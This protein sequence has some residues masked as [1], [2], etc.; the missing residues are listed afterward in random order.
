MGLVG[1]VRALTRHVDFGLDFRRLFSTRLV[2]QCAD[3][4]FQVS[5]AAAVLFSPERETDPKKIAAGFAVLLLPFSIVGPFAGVFLDRWRRQRVL[6]RANLVRT[7]FVMVVA[8]LL[9]SGHGAGPSLYAAALAALSVNRL[10]LA[11]LSASL[12]HVVPRRELVSANS[13][14]TTSGTLVALL[15]GALG[16]GL[17]ALVG[18]GDG[19]SAV[20]ALVGGAG[21]LL[22]AAVAS[23]MGADLLGPVHPAAMP[24][25]TALTGVARGLVAGGR[26]VVGRP[27]AL[28]A[29]LAISAHRFAYGLGLV[30]TL[31][32]Y[33]NYFPD[34]GLLR[35]GL[36]GLAEMSVAAF[37]GI[38][39]AA[40]LTPAVTARVGLEREIVAVLVLAG[41]AE[42]AFGLPFA[43]GPLLA[44]GFFLGLAAQG[45]KICVDTIV[46]ESVDDDFRG[47]VFSLYDTLFNLTFVAAATTGAFVLPV[48]GRSYPVLVGIAACYLL[49]SLG[50]WLA[51]RHLRALRAARRSGTRLVSQPG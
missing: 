18:S 2:S 1:D 17:R 35:A 42:L 30:A 38:V 8:A 7:F 31:L 25:R 21:Y 43:K 32:L 40:F 37:A 4:I 12:P 36:G 34:G 9:L 26:H 14:T 20:I 5:L 33:R 16:V 11:A 46:Q 29:L 23:R 45:S 13:I 50:Y 48:S 19:G 39:V 47:R 24:L 49:T 44:A 28:A 27:R 41:V 51:V 22:A 15:G 3:G 6:V 10:Y